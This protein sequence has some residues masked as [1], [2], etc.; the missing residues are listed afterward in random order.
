MKNQ[1]QL[2]WQNYFSTGFKMNDLEEMVRILLLLKQLSD[3]VRIE[4]QKDSPIAGEILQRI[5]NIRDEVKEVA[6]GQLDAI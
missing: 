3:Y 6:K 5:Q 1:A 4:F 2:I